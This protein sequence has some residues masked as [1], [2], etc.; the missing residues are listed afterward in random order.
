MAPPVDRVTSAKQATRHHKILQPVCKV[1]SYV[2][3][4]SLPYPS[5]DLIREP[6]VNN[7]WCILPVAVPGAYTLL[8][9][10]EPDISDMGAKDGE[11]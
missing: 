7:C 4:A 9:S 5:E 10:R 3:V 11:D 6:R 2:S 8:V 1:L